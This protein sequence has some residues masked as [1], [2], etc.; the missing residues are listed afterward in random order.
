MQFSSTSDLH[1]YFFL[2]VCISPDSFIIGH[3]L[4]THNLEENNYRL[5][6]RLPHIYIQA[7]IHAPTCSDSYVVVQ[8][9][10]TRDMI[11]VC[12]CICICI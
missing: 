4:W 9:M 3:I 5:S 2:C 7:Y 1:I 10:V 11:I 8:D 12:A 6:F